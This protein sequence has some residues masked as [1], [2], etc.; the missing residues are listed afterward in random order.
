MIGKM[1]QDKIRDAVADGLTANHPKA[2]TERVIRNIYNFILKFN[3]EADLV[4]KAL[5]SDPAKKDSQAPL[6]SER[7]APIFIKG[8]VSELRFAVIWESYVF[9]SFVVCVLLGRLEV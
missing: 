9:F 5:M 4:L 8:C 3:H 1:N 7:A 6:R 2:N